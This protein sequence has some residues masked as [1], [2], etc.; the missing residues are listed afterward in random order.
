MAEAK[1]VAPNAAAPA[2]RLAPAGASGDAG[3]QNL[4][5]A[6]MVHA[7]NGDTERVADIDRQLAELGFTVQ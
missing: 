5:G 2:P 3:I 7:S 4:L 6:R 1:K